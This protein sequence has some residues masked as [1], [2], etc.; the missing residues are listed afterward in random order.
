MGECFALHSESEASPF[1]PKTGFSEP[2]TDVN[3]QSKSKPRFNLKI[4]CQVGLDDD[5]DVEL[6]HIVNI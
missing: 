1:S 2:V 4:R 5:D 6:V 3:Y